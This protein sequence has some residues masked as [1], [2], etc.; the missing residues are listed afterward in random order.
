MALDPG[1]EWRCPKPLG[2]G[3][4]QDGEKGLQKP[5]GSLWGGNGCHPCDYGFHQG[6]SLGLVSGSL[7][8]NWRGG[9]QAPRERHPLCGCGQF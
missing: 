2:R 7:E 9:R 1:E 3:V 5:D 6:V 8:E 4:Q